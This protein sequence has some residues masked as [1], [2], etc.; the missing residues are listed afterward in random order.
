MGFRGLGFRAG[1][2]VRGV[3]FVGQGQQ[4]EKV[5]QMWPAPLLLVGF[6]RTPGA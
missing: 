4:L 5:G 1:F 6:C 2:Q 3:R